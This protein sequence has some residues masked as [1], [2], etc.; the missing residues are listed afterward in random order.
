MKNFNLSPFFSRF[1]NTW[2]DFDDLYPRVL[3]IAIIIGSLIISIGTAYL[4]VNISPILSIAFVL[5]IPAI[6]LFLSRPEYG[7]LLVISILPLE[8]LLNQQG[9]FSAIKLISAIAF[10]CAIVNYLLFRPH[11]RFVRSSQNMLIVLF[12]VISLL[13]VFVA[14]SP[15]RTLERLPK[16]LRVIALY[17]IVINFIRSDKHFHWALWLFVIG[18]FLS[19]LY[20]FFDPAQTTGRFEGSL[21][22]SNYYAL[23]MVPRIPL[24]LAL[25]SSQKKYVNKIFLVIMIMTIGYGIILSGSRGGMLSLG[26]ALILYAVLQNKKVLWIG[27][28]SIFVIVGIF[29][30]P[31]EIKMRVGLID[32]PSNSDLGNSTDRRL[33]Y[34]VYGADLFQQ[35]PILGIGLDGFA[36][37]YAQSEY[38]FNIQSKSLRVAHNTYLEIAAGTGVIG[39]LVFLSILG[40]ALYLSL[41]YSQTKY[42]IVNPY[43]TKISVGLFSALGGYFLG[44][45]VGSRQ[46]DKTLWFLL[47]LPIILQFI[48]NSQKKSLQNFSQ[49]SP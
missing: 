27:L 38:R 20:G 30:M 31:Q 7:I 11:Q 18:G 36:E 5:G 32:A 14:I 34:Q 17:F 26:L 49:D 6:L 29:V 42:K 1:S 22:Q 45:L 15:S 43:L 41:K 3:P 35:H 40:S 10:G 16:L 39:L 47:A 25:I 9:G 2:N 33:T 46:Y 24:A 13:S 23:S 44:M 8:E 48:M 4:A 12:I 37:A 28:I 19:T 21:G